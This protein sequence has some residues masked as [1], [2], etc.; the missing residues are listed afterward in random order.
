MSILYIINNKYIYE[1][2]IYNDITIYGINGGFIKAEIN[3]NHAIIY[4][5]YAENTNNIIDLIYDNNIDTINLIEVSLSLLKELFKNIEYIKFE[6][7]MKI[8]PILLDSYNLSYYYISFYGN[9]WL[10]N[11]VFNNNY[12]IKYKN[13]VNNLTNLEMMTWELF[14]EHIVL[15]KK[16]IINYDI[17]HICYYNSK[18]YLEF[19][20]KLK[21]KISK[22]EFFDTLGGNCKEFV[23]ISWYNRFM[24]FLTGSIVIPELCDTQIIYNKDIKNINLVIENYNGLLNKDIRGYKI[25]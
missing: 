12:S 21:Q 3:D 22:N 24:L 19:F 17:I 2:N 8:N 15:D 16:D 23:P 6:V 4:E 7:V 18:T 10:N 20:K 13:I 5:I 9:V 25:L 11:I 14:N 1:T